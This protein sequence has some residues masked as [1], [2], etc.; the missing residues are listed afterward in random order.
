MPT[1]GNPDAVDTIKAIDSL[2]EGGRDDNRD[3]S[4]I[5]TLILAGLN[6]PGVSPIP[7]LFSTGR[8]R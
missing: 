2:R 6:E 3:V 7:L 8:K 1:I 5:L 4:V